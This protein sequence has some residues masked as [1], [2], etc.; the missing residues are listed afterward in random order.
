MMN[1]IAIKAAAVRMR[2]RRQKAFSVMELL[3]SV[4]ILGVIVYALFAVFNQVQKALRSNEAS[5]EVGEKGRAILEMMTRELQQLQPVHTGFVT[6]FLAEPDFT[7]MVFN[8]PDDPRAPG[9][10]NSLYRVYFPAKQGHEW[11]H[12]EYRIDLAENR[13]GVL[14]RFAWTNR[15]I[16]PYELG[17][18][19][20]NAYKIDVTNEVFFH[21]FADGVTHFRVSAYDRH[22]GLLS[23]NT[24]NKFAPFKIFRGSVTGPMGMPKYSDV[25]LPEDANIRIRQAFPNNE[26]ENRLEFVSN[27]VPAYL[28]VE[29]G[30]LEPETLRQYY[31]MIKD[32]NPNAT[33]FLSRQIAKVHVFRQRIP[34]RTAAQ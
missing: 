28:E 17:L 21:H 4:A 26:E 20:S 23:Y 15:I 22:G 27:A 2:V 29:L 32:Q 16:T 31:L 30:V 19:Q 34:I 11:L 14:K 10:T 5:T 33:N 7:P 3:L 6:N 13:V 25:A 1:W 8:A 12:L 9:R 18:V 24:T